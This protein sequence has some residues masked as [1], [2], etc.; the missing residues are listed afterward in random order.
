MKQIQDLDAFIIN[1]ERLA[2]TLVNNETK[3]TMSLVVEDLSKK[4]E[5]KV[6]FDSDGSLITGER[7]PKSILGFSAF[8]FE[9]LTPNPTI[10]KNELDLNIELPVNLALNILGVLLYSKNGERE[11]LKIKL[12][13][14]GVEI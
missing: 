1:L 3:T 6:R 7:R 2:E 9:F 5:E 13:K 10:T 11:S 14:I 8:H 12:K 4:E